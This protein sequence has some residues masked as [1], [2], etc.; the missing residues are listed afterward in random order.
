MVRG[1]L[2]TLSLRLNAIIHSSINT[3]VKITNSLPFRTNHTNTYSQQWI[4]QPSLHKLNDATTL[5]SASVNLL[6]HTSSW[7]AKNSHR[8][9]LTSLFI[10]R[11]LL[12]SLRT[13]RYT[14]ERQHLIKIIIFLTFCQQTFQGVLITW[15]N[16]IKKKLEVL[17]MSAFSRGN[18]GLWLQRMPVKGF[19]NFYFPQNQNSGGMLLVLPCS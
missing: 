9:N 10:G 15:S 1:T 17:S 19:N 4:T 2:N 14:F 7:L 6:K 8:L 11:L 16:S 13:V 3:K 5:V 18:Y 12:T